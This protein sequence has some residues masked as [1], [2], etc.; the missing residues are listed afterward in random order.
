[1]FGRQT[2][3]KVGPWN[4]LSRCQPRL[5]VTRKGNCNLRKLCTKLSNHALDIVWDLGCLNALQLVLQYENF[6]MHSYVDGD[7]SK[8]G[9]LQAPWT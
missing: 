3:L 8:P 5:Y 9:A 7:H 1:M 2:P 4:L 6:I